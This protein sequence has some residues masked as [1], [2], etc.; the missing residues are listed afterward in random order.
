MVVHHQLSARRAGRLLLVPEPVLPAHPAAGPAVQH[1]P[2]GPGVDPQAAH[3][4]RRPSP[5]WSR[6]PT[7]RS[8][9]PIEGE[10]VFD[11]VTFGYDPDVP[12]LHDV[13]LRD[14]PG[15]DG[16][17]RR[18]RPGPAS[19]PWPSWS[20]A[21]TTRPAA[22]CCIDGHDL[23]RRD[24][25]TRCAASSASSPRSRSSSPAPIRDNIAFARPDATD[26]EVAEAVRAVGLTELVEPAARRRRH[27]RP[28]AGPVPVLGRAPADRPGPGLP[29]PSPGAGARRGHLQPRPA[30]RD[31]DRGRARRPA[32]GP[33]RRAH[34]PPAVDGHEGRPDRRRR[35]RPDRRDRA[36]RR[37]GGPPA[38]ATPRCTPPGPNRA[39][40]P[41]DLA[42]GR[43]VCGEQ[44][45][46]ALQDV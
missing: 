3:A 17:L 36:P 14:R 45:P 24:H 7:P 35:R 16:G 40:T 27:R 42:G 20:P 44:C 34:R 41:T 43:S 11:D 26:D 38:G 15:R 46:A 6:P 9:R 5:R 1:L 23:A 29:G 28:R 8:C 33:H 19:R 22:G 10:I 4:A 37:A 39:R 25:A 13:D 2:A 21:S 30:V 18:A 32:R 31:Q 12:V